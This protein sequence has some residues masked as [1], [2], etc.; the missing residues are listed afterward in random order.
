MII[1]RYLYCPST[2][3]QCIARKRGRQWNSILQSSE[4]ALGAVYQ[5]CGS[6]KGIQRCRVGER[7]MGDPLDMERRIQKFE[8]A[9]LEPG[10]GM[11]GFFTYDFFRH[12][13]IVGRCRSRRGSLVYAATTLK[14]EGCL[15]Q[16]S[17]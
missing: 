5:R 11:R 16:D 17:A 14:A 10:V 13:S 15:L 2:N 1:N 3:K 8:Q 9:Y 12:V 6:R 7:H 4:A